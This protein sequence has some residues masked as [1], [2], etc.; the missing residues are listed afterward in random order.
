MP[1]EVAIP[2]IISVATALVVGGR[3]ASTDVAKAISLLTLLR[4]DFKTALVG[5]EALRIIDTDTDARI[6]NLEQRTEDL[7][8]YLQLVSKGE[9]PH[10]FSPRATRGEKRPKGA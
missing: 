10:P 4:E 5:I 2:L 7:E 1:I 6:R 3:R 9:Y 8:R